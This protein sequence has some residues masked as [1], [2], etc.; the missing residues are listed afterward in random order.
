MFRT[1]TATATFRTACWMGER[2]V[3]GIDPGSRV[4]GYGLVAVTP[5]GAGYLA[6][7]C[8]RPRSAAFV[9]RLGEIYHGIAA[10]I[11]EHAPD[12]VAIEQVFLASNPASALKLG[13]ARGA[14]IA[15]AAAA[16]LPV[17]EYAARTVKLAVVGSGRASKSQVQHMVRV[18]L[19]LSGTPAADAAD[20]LAIALCHVNTARLKPPQDSSATS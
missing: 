11:R 3:L 19:R 8:I 7:G 18:L 14:A 10:L 12:E 5:R 4:T 20:A 1:C 15:A 6:S 9:D 13:Q 2:R 16:G 17:A